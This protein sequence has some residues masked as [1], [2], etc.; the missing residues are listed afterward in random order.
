MAALAT[1]LLALVLAV[2]PPVPLGSGGRGGESPEAPDGHR[3]L[4]ADTELSE[5]LKLFK[6]RREEER[7]FVAELLA[8]EGDVEE[9]LEKLREVYARRDYF[10]LL[11]EDVEPTL[12]ALHTAFLDANEQPLAAFARGDAASLAFARMFLDTR[13]RARIAVTGGWDVEAREVAAG[14]WVLRAMTDGW[15]VL[16]PEEA[17]AIVTR[18]DLSS[19]LLR[20]VRSDLSAL[21]PAQKP[22]Q[23]VD[24]AALTALLARA[25]AADEVARRAALSE[26]VDEARRKEEMMV[27]A[28]FSARLRRRADVIATI[29][30]R[31]RLWA[32]AAPLRADALVFLPDTPEG[33]E[34][35]PEVAEMKT[36]ERLKW[37]G[38]RGSEGMAIDPLDDVLV[39][40]A[41]HAT[42]FQWGSIQARELYD[43]YLALRRIRSHEYE[44][45][46][47]RELTAWENEALAAVQRSVMPEDAA[48]LR[49]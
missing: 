46:R 34:A 41:A 42:D 27:S 1:T 3:G 9:Q 31:E 40:A 5:L 7:A 21:R 30:W 10:D 17:R 47:G 16:V 2:P 14:I 19:A 39:F 26:A 45:L 25:H 6:T 23:V 28:L 8:I 29:D 38:W 11:P 22:Q 20:A 24:D 36:H 33:R 35:P 4:G 43:R 15:V 18:V 49:R 13:F 48:G 32:R 37:A 12:G 44:T